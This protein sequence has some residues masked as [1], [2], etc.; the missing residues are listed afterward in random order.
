MK[1]CSRKVILSLCAG[2]YIQCILTI[3]PFNG[4]GG[5]GDNG[6]FN[7]KSQFYTD[8]H[9]FQSTKLL[10][11]SLYSVHESIQLSHCLAIR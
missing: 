5:G 4:G 6:N 2:A 7:D 11:H 3:A 9:V 1:F 8:L 10:A